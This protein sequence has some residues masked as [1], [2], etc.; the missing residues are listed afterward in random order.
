[1]PM[2]GTVYAPF[3]WE[4]VMIFPT[5]HAIGLKSDAGLELLIHVGLDTVKLDGK[6][7]DLFVTDGQKIQR[8]DMLLKAD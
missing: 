4:V 7:F 8:G 1:R 2:D 6:G 3:D 5:K